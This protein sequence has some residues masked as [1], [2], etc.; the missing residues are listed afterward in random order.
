MFPCRQT[1]V[2]RDWLPQHGAECGT[3]KLC[4]AQLQVADK[5][6]VKVVTG[7]DDGLRRC[8]K[9]GPIENEWDLV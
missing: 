8:A 4:Q 2:T 5:S 3:K 6:A 9:G 1:A 7:C